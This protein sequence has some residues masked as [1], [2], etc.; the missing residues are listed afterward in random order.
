MTSE[1]TPTASGNEPGLARWPFWRANA[2]RWTPHRVWDDDGVAAVIQVDRAG[3]AVLIGLGEPAP[4]AR[5]LADIEAAADVPAVARAMLTRG[6]WTLVPD[7]VRR[8]TGLR[9]GRPWDWLSTAAD[10]PRHDGEDRV[11]PLPGG[12]EQAHA[13]LAQAYPERGVHDDDASLD[14]WAYPDPAGA[15]AA[16]M[17]ARRHA[18]GAPV[19]LSA[20][21]VLPEHRRRGLAATLVAAVTRRA[22]RETAMV[23]LGIWA[24]S[25]DARRLYTRLGFDTGHQLEN[26]AR[27]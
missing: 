26:L 23:H 5:L 13:I 11:V 9:V 7:D 18:P 16:V 24:D 14:W 6:T 25:D 10:P 21:G 15:P 4:L 12:V 20:V 8:R 1:P 2:D 22:L 3:E 19:H 27:A 17:A